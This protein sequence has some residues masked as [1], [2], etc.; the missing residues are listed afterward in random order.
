M[1]RVAA[2]LAPRRSALAALAALAL[3]ACQ[4]APVPSAPPL[5]PSPTPTADRIP[6]EQQPTAGGTLRYAISEPSAIVPVEAVGSA[7]HTVV[8]ALFDSLTYWAPA[9]GADQAVS[10]LHARPSAAVSWS[11]A[12]EARTWTFELRPRATFHDGSPVTAG[13]FAFAWEQAVELDQVGYHLRE[14]EGYDALRTGQADRLTGVTALDDHTLQVRL[15]RPNAEFPAVVGH[16]ALGPLPRELWEADPASFRTRPVG[17]GPFAA[18]EAWAQGQFVRVTPFDGWSNR[19]AK[20]AV[21]EVV[22]QVMDLDT[23]YLA[24]QQGR[25]DFTQLPAGALSDA[26]E[27]Y[28]ESPD[29]YTG[30]GVLRGEVPVLYYLGFNVTQPPFDDVEVR[31]A[32]SQAIDRVALTGEVREGNLTVARSLVPSVLPGFRG[33]ACPTCRHDPEAAEAVFAE[34]GITSLALWFNRDGGHDRVA[35]LLR[36]DLRAVGVRLELRTEEFPQYLETLE[37]GEAGLYRFGWAVDYPTVDNALYPILHTSAR[38][39]GDSGYNYGGYSA[40]DVDALLDE[41]R[42]TTEEGRRHALYGQAADLALNRDQMAVPLFTYRHAA[43]ASDRLDGLVYD[44]MGSVDLVT[45]GIA[46]PV[47]GDAG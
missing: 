46:D 39:G 20:P 26:I 22:F 32:V 3:T 18:S 36:R 1:G 12:D 23:A 8:D 10:D 31:R 38:G 28:G 16:P 27:E 44:P 33:A 13:D 45:V 7:A 34:R 40:E 29:G 35:R 41:A 11:S 42:A 14:V 21:T 25:L 37:S 6:G 47:D 17:N 9:R 43:V 24:F 2:P 5:P 4:A 30:P 15:T 19:V